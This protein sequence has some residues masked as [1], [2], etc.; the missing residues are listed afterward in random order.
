MVCCCCAKVIVL[1][2]HVLSM[3]EPF[4]RDANVPAATVPPP[5]I[6]QSGWLPSDAVVYQ[7]EYIS[8]KLT[9]GG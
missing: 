3:H 5:A 7:M 8:P 2:L 1:A 4:R 9:A 6:V